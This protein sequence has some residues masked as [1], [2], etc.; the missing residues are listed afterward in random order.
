[1]GRRNKGLE[2]GH[3]IAET[4]RRQETRR[5]RNKM[6]RVSDESVCYASLVI[7]EVSLY[8]RLYANV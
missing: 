8:R 1:M 3:Y 7:K 5:H 2:D 4:E 6:A